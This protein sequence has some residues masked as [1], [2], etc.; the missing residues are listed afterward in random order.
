[1][2]CWLRT[3]R[4]CRISRYAAESTADAGSATELRKQAATLGIER[5]GLGPLAALNVLLHGFGEREDLVQ[6]YH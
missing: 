1:M 6:G 4:C 3:S 2:V 5:A